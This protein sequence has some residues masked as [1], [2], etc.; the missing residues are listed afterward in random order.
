MSGSTHR[1]FTPAA[2]SWAPCDG[3]AKTRHPAAERVNIAP[4]HE[5][6]AVSTTTARVAISPREGEVSL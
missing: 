5:V 1:R 4:A 3:C 2:R 6:L